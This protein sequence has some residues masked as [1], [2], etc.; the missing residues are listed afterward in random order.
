MHSPKLKSLYIAATCSGPFLL[1][2][3]S[4]AVTLG[5][6]PIYST[7]ASRTSFFRSSPRWWP[8]LTDEIFVG[9]S[10]RVKVDLILSSK[11]DQGLM[12]SVDAN[13]TRMDITPTVTAG[14]T[15]LAASEQIGATSNVFQTGTGAAEALGSSI[16]SL[17]QILEAVVKVM[18]SISEVIVH[19]RVESP[20]CEIWPLPT[21]RRIHSWR[22][23]GKCF[24]PYTR[25]IIRL[26]SCVM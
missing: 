5:R 9:P 26:G 16:S 11:P 20:W 22:P 17:E 1:I 3:T 6:S 10:T 14:L 21:L 4:L 12:E 24:R 8:P 2:A 23:H 15:V 18:D 25:L 13:I 7:M 19:C